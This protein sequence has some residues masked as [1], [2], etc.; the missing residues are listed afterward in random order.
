MKLLLT[1]GGITNDTLAKELETLAGKPFA[2]LKIGFIPTAAFGDPSEDKAWLIRDMH[3]LVERGAT[4]AVIS[5]SDRTQDE[6]AAQLEPVDVIFVGGGDTFYLSWIMQQKGLFALIPRLLETKVYASI[7]AGSMIMTPSLAAVSHA[8]MAG[9]VRDD[10]GPEERSSAQTLGLVSF[11]VRPHLN[12]HLVDEIN[13][14]VLEKIAA[15]TGTTIYAIDDNS[16][17][18]VDG[19]EIT[20]VGEGNWKIIR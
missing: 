15:E 12:S 9:G 20:P 13:G 19:D 7:S 17:V 3:R 14:G 6:I 10:L 4:V 5:L 2:Q 16:A 1:S 18:K 11:M 8:I